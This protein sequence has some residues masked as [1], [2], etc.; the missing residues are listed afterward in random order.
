MD[1][2]CQNIEWGKYY[3]KFDEDE[4]EDEWYFMEDVLQK[5]YHYEPKEEVKEFIEPKAKLTKLI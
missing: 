4:Q 3:L 1:K 5:V 2:G